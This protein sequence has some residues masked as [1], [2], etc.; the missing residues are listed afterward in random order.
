MQL[1]PRSHKQNK[2]Q[3][4]PRTC[5]CKK[6]KFKKHAKSLDLQKSCTLICKSRSRES[7]LDCWLIRTVAKGFA[8][9][10]RPETMH[11]EI[12]S[13]TIPADNT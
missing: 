2:Q 1:L 10:C 11:L 3:K 8:G 9:C 12:C 6:K 7:G 13:F 5:I 4:A